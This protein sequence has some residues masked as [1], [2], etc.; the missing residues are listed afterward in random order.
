MPIGRPIPNSTAYVFDRHMMLMPIGAVGELYV[1]GVGLARGYLHRPALTAE[2]FVMNPHVAGERLYRTGDLVRRRADGV[3]EFVGRADRQVKIRGFR[4]EPGEIES[5]LLEDGRLREVCVVPAKADDG[6]AFLCAYYIAAA[7]VDAQELRQHLSARLPAYM[8][9]S[10]YC[11]LKRMPLTDNGK[12]DLRALPEPARWRAEPRSARPPESAAEIAIAGVWEELLDARNI[13]ATANFFE[14][15]GH[16]LKASALASR[17]SRMFGLKI[18]LRNVFDSPTVA[19]LARLV[20]TLAQAE[21]RDG[22]TG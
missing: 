10:A 12:I 20:A 16:S 19:E 5:R 6:G 21:H 15:G 17:L 18:T 4:I 22:V 1:G 9:P 13:G 11:R 8:V 2:R 14:I 3:L 7:D